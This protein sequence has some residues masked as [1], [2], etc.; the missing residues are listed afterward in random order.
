VSSR[1]EADL[2]AEGCRP[3]L[4]APG[5]ALPAD[6]QVAAFRDMLAPCGVGPD[7][8]RFDC[9]EFPCLAFLRYDLLD[10]ATCEGLEQLAATVAP[11][12]E[13]FEA[14]WAAVPL[15]VG[16]PSLGAHAAAFDARWDARRRS[17]E[18]WLADEG[19]TERH[20]LGCAEL[21]S[22]TAEAADDCDR[23]RRRRGCEAR[24]PQ[25]P[26]ELVLAHR[27]AAQDL[28]DQLVD[29]CGPFPVEEYVLDCS[30][31]PCLLVVP[32]ADASYPGNDPVDS[33]VGDRV[34]NAAWSHDLDGVVQQGHPRSHCGPVA[35]FPLW[36]LGDLRRDAPVVEERYYE[37]RAS[38]RLL[39]CQQLEGR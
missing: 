3:P 37:V 8:V 4:A 11:P 30:D 1:C 32:V 13:G 29:T 22:I 20:E 2:I 15:A 18:P 14:T 7:E 35:V 12:G 34:C 38:R 6:E 25:V 39:A 21:R 23:E 36:D 19:P 10:R 27:T 9:S 28:V 17:F 26:P 5:E 16:S 31:L 33:H 24:Q